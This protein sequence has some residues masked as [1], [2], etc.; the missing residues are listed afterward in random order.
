MAT[1]NNRNKSKILMITVMALRIMK[2][3]LIFKIMAIKSNQ[4][5]T[6]IAIINNKNY[7]NNIWTNRK[8]Q[9]NTYYIQK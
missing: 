2:I 5:I 6:F 1:I 7:N 3:W 9:T 4:I 8:K